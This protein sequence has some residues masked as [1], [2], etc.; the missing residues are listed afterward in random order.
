M[1]KKFKLITLIAITASLASAQ[2][3]HYRTRSFWTRS[4]YVSST[5]TTTT[6]YTIQLEGSLYE[7]ETTQSPAGLD[8]NHYWSTQTYPEHFVTHTRIHRTVSPSGV[9]SILSVPAEGRGT[10]SPRTDLGRVAYPYM[11]QGSQCYGVVEGRHTWHVPP[12]ET[13]EWYLKIAFAIIQPVQVGEDVTLFAGFHIMPFT[14]YTLTPTLGCLRNFAGAVPLTPGYVK[15]MG[16]SSIPWDPA[17]AVS[18]CATG[19][20]EI[21]L[22]DS[23]AP[24][25]I[26]LWEK[27]NVSNLSVS[28]VAQVA[29]FGPPM[30]GG[31]PGDPGDPILP[32]DE[33]RTKRVTF[34]GA[35]GRVFL[36]Q[37]SDDCINWDVC[38][39]A[40]EITAGQ[41]VFDDTRVSHTMRLFK[42]IVAE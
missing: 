9:S 19:G 30:P 31:N 7:R 21:S 4:D 28:L 35:S 42:V 12:R 6:K 1:N 14:S 27:G 36:I 33:L 17:Y 24:E 15:G 11:W 41:W 23:P 34:S 2:V 22:P 8:Q 39:K 18:E 26:L 10:S 3:A 20:S 38:G 29:G 32:T 25:V 40:D 37:S 5:G 16:N 13:Q